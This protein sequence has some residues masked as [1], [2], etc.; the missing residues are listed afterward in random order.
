MR[1]QHATLG[2]ELVKIRFSANSFKT[3]RGV[4]VFKL[5]LAKNCW[6]LL[7]NCSLFTS[8]SYKLNTAE[9]VLLSAVQPRTDSS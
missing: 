9:M 5:L 8:S 1:S 3:A 2:N 7:C 6:I 4:A